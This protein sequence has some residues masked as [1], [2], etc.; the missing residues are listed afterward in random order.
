MF[1]PIVP[2]EEVDARLAVCKD[3]FERFNILHEHSETFKAIEHDYKTLKYMNKQLE[4][5]LIDAHTFKVK[6]ALYDKMMEV[7]NE[8]PELVD[9][10]HALLVKAKLA[11]AD[12]EAE[13]NDIDK[14]LY[15]K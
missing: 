9:D 4:L 5:E 11:N 14:H 7:F 15:K 10:W 2:I 8:H 3:V 12:I 6:A 1:K 13:L